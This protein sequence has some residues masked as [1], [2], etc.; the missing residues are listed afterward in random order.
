MH[1][2]PLSMQN[3]YI[4]KRGN[5][6][7]RVPKHQTTP[8]LHNRYFNSPAFQLV[9]KMFRYAAI[10]NDLIHLFEPANTAKAA[11]AEFGRIGKY[12]HFL[13][14]IDHLPVQV[15]FHHAGCSE[16]EF[17]IDTIYPQE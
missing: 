3:N 7:T 6:V 10:G 16:T 14:H 17:Q 15:C 13:R 1:F 9:Y 11:L 4:C 5:I 8:N 12:D 2:Y